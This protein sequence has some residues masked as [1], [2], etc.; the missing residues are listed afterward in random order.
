MRR[1]VKLSLLF[2]SI[3]I[4]QQSV[5][6]RPLYSEPSSWKSPLANNIEISQ[7]P[8]TTLDCSASWSHC[9]GSWNMCAVD[10]KVGVGT[11]I[12]APDGGNV[13]RTGFDSSG[14]GNFLVLEHGGRSSLYL[15][16]NK[17]IVKSGEVKQGDVIGCS[18]IGGTGPHLHFSA[19]TDKSLKSCIAMDGIDGNTNFSR[20]QTFSTSNQMNGDNPC[21]APVVITPQPTL[22]P[23]TGT[24]P[25]SPQLISPENN[26]QRDQQTSVNFQWNFA[27]G[28]TQY[29]LEYSGGP[30]GTLQSGWQLGAGYSVGT[31]WPGSYTW[32]VKARNSAGESPWSEQRVFTIVESQTPITTTSTA[33]NQVLIDS[34]S[35][36]QVQNQVSDIPALRSPKNNAILSQ[37]TDVWF[38]WEYAENASQYYLEYWGDPYGTLNSGWTNDIAY[39]IGTM[40]SGSFSWHVKSRNSQGQESEWSPTRVF[41][42]NQPENLASPIPPATI[43]PT[44]V[45][46]TFTPVS[47][48]TQI[49][50]VGFIQLIDDLSLRTESGNWPPQSGEKI[51][52]HIRVRNGGDL[53]LHV[54]HL[55]VR[56]RRNGSDSWDIGF[57]SVDLNGHQEWSLDPNN[58]RPLESGNYS[59]RISYT[60]DG[61]SWV[62][63]G[64]E[65][66]FTVQ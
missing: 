49:P 24:P 36:V 26:Q 53:L 35:T 13:V 3:F 52:A 41:K 5:S 15:H 29:L 1:S 44:A 8:A 23:S 46:P 30:Y 25:A 55:G 61:S 12:L 48:P 11:P 59:F 2:L 20:G 31:M 6:A 9:K 43:Q 51:I 66:N 19:M 42:I 58:E 27:N 56:G 37:S 57:W 18:G 65:I 10:L 17:F 54:Q 14:G 7:G 34:T 64:N 28:A 4:I 50:Q 40:W 62:E 21:T 47:P 45:P 32:R 63:V 38:E 22:P 39:H 33:T 16:L 60:L